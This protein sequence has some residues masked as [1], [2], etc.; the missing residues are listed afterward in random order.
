MVVVEKI[1]NY[2]REFSNLMA[3][4]HHRVFI[5]LFHDEARASAAYL[6]RDANN[7]YHFEAPIFKSARESRIIQ[8]EG[9]SSCAV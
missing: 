4:A 3:K 2:L 7:A 9:F 8:L 6:R 1:Q 5:A